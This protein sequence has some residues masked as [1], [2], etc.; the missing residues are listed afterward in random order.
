MVKGQIVLLGAG[1]G[2]G[3]EQIS[4]FNVEE[5]KITGWRGEDFKD[6]TITVKI[7]SCW[8]AHGCCL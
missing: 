4:V 5:D 2:G 6:F 7:P 3:T 8:Y 1:E